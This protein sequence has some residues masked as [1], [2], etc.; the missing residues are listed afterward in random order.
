[1]VQTNN[2]DNLNILSFQTDL[3]TW[4]EKEQRNLPWRTDKNPYKIWISEIMLQQTKVDTVIPYFHHFIEQ[5]PTIQTL[6]RADEDQVL[7]AWEGLGYYSR[8]R[9]LHHAAKEVCEKYDGKIPRTRKE[10]MTLK[11]IGPYTAGAILS[12]AFHVP[13]HAVDG[14]VMRVLARILS[15]SDDIAKASSRK[16]FEQAVM[17]M[18]SHEKPASFN[19]GLMEL[20]ALICTPTTPAC[21]H[22]PVREH[23]HAFQMGIQEKLPVKSKKKRPRSVQLVVAVLI[24]EK[25]RLL[26]QKRGSDGL[27]ANLWEFPTI[28]T[29][30]SFMNEK[31]QLADFVE[32][33]YHTKAQLQEYLFSLEH[34]F[35]HL[36]WN[37]RVYTGKLSGGLQEN[38]Q[39][40]LVYPDQLTTYAFPVSHQ[41]IYQKYIEQMSKSI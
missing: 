14:N 19:Q 9:N 34:I 2:L 1:M 39:V 41:K 20:G 30:L 15:I 23:C 27:L 26:I 37:M 31:E 18:I 5:F 7:K 28:E 24:D 6:A 4:F 3:I 33:T 38:N 17:K 36:V 40:K 8:A 32:K 11:G 13:E 29:H 12:I 35:T 16:I 25:G 21:L 22:C 10:I